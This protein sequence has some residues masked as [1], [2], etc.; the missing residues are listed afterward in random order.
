MDGGAGPGGGGGG[1]AAAAGGAAVGAVELLYTICALG[2]PILA[3]LCLVSGEAARAPAA[4]AA[5]HG[6][7]GA[8]GFAGWAGATAVTEGLLTGCVIL[9]TQLNSALTTSIVGV[10]KGV[11]SSVLGF[12]L[13]GGVRFHAVNVAGIAIN[14]AGGIWYSGVQYVRHQRG[15]G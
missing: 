5:V 1:T 3:V 6:R 7:M 9:C 14:T 13:L 12:F 8:G 11:V 4:L 10:L 2:V 15:G